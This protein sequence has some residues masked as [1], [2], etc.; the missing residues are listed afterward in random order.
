MTI[1]FRTLYRFDPDDLDSHIINVVHNAFYAL[2]TDHTMELYLQW[3]LK[4]RARLLQQRSAVSTGQWSESRARMNQVNPLYVLR[5]YMAQSAIDLAGE[6]DY[7]MIAKL[8]ELL[9]N[10][11][12]T[13]VGCEHFAQKRPE[14]ARHKA[15][16]SALSCSS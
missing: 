16:C 10:P 7:A 3:E 14:W 6:G 9:R 1:F 5:N 13:Q 8:L 2:P 15:G 12:K 4:Y 11:Y